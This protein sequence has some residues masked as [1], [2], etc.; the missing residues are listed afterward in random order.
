MPRNTAP[1]RAAQESSRRKKFQRN[2]FSIEIFFN[3]NCKDLTG[4]RGARFSPREDVLTFS[5]LIYLTPDQQK[6]SLKRSK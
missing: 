2:F 1:Q 3:S 6:S 5:S 4:S